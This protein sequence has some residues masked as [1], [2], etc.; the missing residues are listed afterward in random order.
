MKKQILLGLS[1]TAI[2]LIGVAILFPVFASARVSLGRAMQTTIYQNSIQMVSFW[3]K[4]VISGALVW[5]LWHQPIRWQD[6]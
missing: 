3:Q 6:E 4:M 2:L 1:A 5:W